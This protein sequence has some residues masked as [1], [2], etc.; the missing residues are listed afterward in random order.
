MPDDLSIPR[1]P[2][3]QIDLWDI[4]ST[5][6]HIKSKQQTFTLMYRLMGVQQDEQK[7]GFAALVDSIPTALQETDFAM[8]VLTMNEVNLYTLYC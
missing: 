1:M 2:R 8:E 4:T 7:N 6:G 3:K 5:S